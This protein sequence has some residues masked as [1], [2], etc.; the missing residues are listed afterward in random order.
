[1]VDGE[2]EIDTRVSERKAS[3]RRKGGDV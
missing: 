3:Y 2:D 1:M